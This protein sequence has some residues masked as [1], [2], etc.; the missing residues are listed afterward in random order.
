VERLINVKSAE[1]SDL[2]KGIKLS[3][4]MIKN[5]VIDT[6]NTIP[7]IRIKIKRLGNKSVTKINL[8]RQ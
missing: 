1:I 7:I 3:G 8:I 2:G 4:Q 6:I 5:G